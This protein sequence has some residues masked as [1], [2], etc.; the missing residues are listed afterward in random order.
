[1]PIGVWWGGT[2]PLKQDSDDDTL[3]DNW[4]IKYGLDPNDNGTINP[5]NG[6]TGDPDEDDLYNE[7]E[8]R[9]GASPK[10]PDSDNDGMPDGWEVQHSLDP[11]LPGDKN[12]DPDGDGLTNIQE[13][14]NNTHPNNNDT[15]NDS[16][17]DSWELDHGLSPID[18]NAN[19]DLDGDELTNIEE[20]NV[21]TE[22][23]KQDT[24]GDGLFDGYELKG[25]FPYHR[26]FAH[27]YTESSGEIVSTYITWQK[28]EP[29]KIQA[30]WINTTDYVVYNIFIDSKKDIGVSFKMYING[31]SDNV[32]IPEVEGGFGGSDNNP[33]KIPIDKQGFGYESSTF[34]IRSGNLDTTVGGFNVKITNVDSL[35]YVK[36]TSIE[37]LRQGGCNPTNPDTD[38]DGLSD[39]VEPYMDNGYITSPMIAD[40]DYDGLSDGLEMGKRDAGDEDIST[41]TDP[42]RQDTD[43]DRLMDSEEDQN[44][45]GR[46]DDGETDPN[47]PDCDGD[48]VIDG[49]DCYPN[50]S[51]EYRDIDGDGIGDHND[52]DDDNDGFLDIWESYLG[53][54]TTDNNSKPLDTDSDGIPDGDKNNSQEWMDTDDDNDNMLDLDELKAG[55]DPLV[56]NPDKKDKEPDDSTQKDKE[57]VAGI[58]SSGL[59][60]GIIIT[61]IVV[62]MLIFLFLFKNK[63]KGKAQGETNQE[64]KQDQTIPTSNSGP[65]HLPS[66]SEETKKIQNQPPQ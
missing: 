27:D 49:E 57:P 54:D 21:G 16:M 50:N 26:A 12:K 43:N 56:K 30:I 13:F 24:D 29:Y 31:L 14:H 52:T 63:I 62:I 20:F 66:S 4:E 55:T 11:V 15:D 39:G 22:P 10:D 40:T 23:T 5:D 19:E 51:L 1:M 28:P 60:I 44:F 47:N 8:Y 7:G 65:P 61:I 35:R 45:N 36:I 58:D 17:P 33:I 59:M 48:G 64:I 46:I 25:Y 34:I 41:T 38:G 6:K 9:W 18:S 37:L 3:P 53:T 32:D 42:T 2:D